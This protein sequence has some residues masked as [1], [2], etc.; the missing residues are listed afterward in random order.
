M[1][2]MRLNQTDR[3][4]RCRFAT[5]HRVERRKQRTKRAKERR[6]IMG[7]LPGISSGINSDPVSDTQV[8]GKSIISANISND[9]A[10]TQFTSLKEEN[11]LVSVQLVRGSGLRI[12][13]PNVKN[14]TPHPFA[15]PPLPK[16]LTNIYS[17]KFDRNC[18]QLP[19]YAFHLPRLH[20]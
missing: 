18:V 15:G 5:L 20:Q 13:G 2:M 12:E 14:I 4:T 1:S 8:E 3:M 16:C 11:V 9:A 10:N 19:N 6:A 17:P 7:D